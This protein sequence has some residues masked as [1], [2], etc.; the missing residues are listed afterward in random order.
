MATWEE[1]AKD[2]LESAKLLATGGHYRSSISRAYYA[3]FSA[4]AGILQHWAPFGC[5]PTPP[6]HRLVSLLEHHFKAKNGHPLR[7]V[8]SAL[9]RLYNYRIS[10]DYKVGVQA[11]K[12][13]ALEAQRDAHAVCRFLGVC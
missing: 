5:R 9:R 11:D 6:H 3:A 12:D 7:T 2:N 4:S 8:K 1:I 13:E 10:A